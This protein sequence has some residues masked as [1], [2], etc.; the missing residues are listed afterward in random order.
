MTTAE[1]L[2]EL[3]SYGSASIKKV[4]M[5]HGAKEPFYGVKVEDLKKIQKKIKK[6]YQLALEL[7][8]TGISDAMY[9]AGLIADDQK[10]TK[11]NLNHWARNAYWYMI[12]EYTVPW[13]AAESHYGHELAMEWIAS[14]VEHI[15][16]SGWMTYG[17]LLALT[18]DD[19]LNKE[20]IKSLLAT[21]EKTIHQAQNRVKQAMNAFVIATGSYV[22]E[23]TEL[24]EETGKRIGTVM[25]DMGGTACKTPYSPEYIDKVRQRG[26]IGKKKK[27]V[28]C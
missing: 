24:A 13:V 21:I 11:S 4:H 19:K 28:K 27:T 1:I 3:K 2:E 8:D 16:A 26:S 18:P 17:S 12:S 6:D 15:I 14:D 22:P 25:V 10:M 5:N 20:E 7:Y 9:L 23:L